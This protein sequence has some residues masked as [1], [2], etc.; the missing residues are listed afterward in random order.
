MQAY[1]VVRSE[2]EGGAGIVL[3]AGSFGD[4]RV[5]GASGVPG[6]APSQYL[7]SR[8]LREWVGSYLGKWGVFSGCSAG[9][10]WGME[11]R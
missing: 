11:C 10:H 7:G 3:Q 2:P 8:L 5:G 9:S 1:E 4:L 6:L